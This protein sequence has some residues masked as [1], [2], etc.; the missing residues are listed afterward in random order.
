MAGRD[1]EYE[2]R[3]QQIIDGALAVFSEKGFDKAT[4]QE[5]AEAA[6]IAS[7]GLI[8]HYFESKADL[9][10]QVMSSRAPLLQSVMRD[11]ALLEMPPRQALTLI[12]SAFL[13]ALS[14]ADN[15]RLFR[16]TIGESMR[17]P[18]MTA[19]WHRSSSLPVKRGLVRY[20]EAKMEAGELRRADPV[21]ASDCFLG[22]F[23]IYVLSGE[24]FGP[25]DAQRLEPQTMLA[26][27]VE[28]FLRGLEAA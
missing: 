2:H 14:N 23:M 15:L 18:D 10:R 25:A 12:G 28:I 13:D 19:A 17:N 16:L 11:Q 24:M 22:S 27:A 7:P 20:L 26:A 4:N 8:Y 6:G 21:A 1:E 3:R 5:I 9:L